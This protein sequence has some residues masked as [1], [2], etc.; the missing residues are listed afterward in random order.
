MTALKVSADH[1]CVQM[2]TCYVFHFYMCHIMLTSHTYELTFMLG[3]GLDGGGVGMLGHVQLCSWPKLGSLKDKFPQKYKLNHYLLNL[4]PI[5]RW[6]KFCSPQNI[7]G[8]SQCCSILTEQDGYKK[9]T[10]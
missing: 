2:Y 3:G 7:S 1:G 5:E 10:V 6:V 8:D 9:S 4:M